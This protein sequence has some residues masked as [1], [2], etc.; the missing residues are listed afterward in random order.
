[1]IVCVYIYKQDLNLPPFLYKLLL[2]K[3]SLTAEK[4]KVSKNGAL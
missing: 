1:M 2:K 3:N 4:F